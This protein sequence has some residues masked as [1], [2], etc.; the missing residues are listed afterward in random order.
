MATK[1]VATAFGGPEVLSVV[2]ADVP[3]PGAGEV[4]VKVRAAAINPIDFKRFSGAV[5][6]DPST[7]PQPVGSELAGVV[8]AVGDDAEGP[9]GPVSPGDEVVVYPVTGAFA[10]AVT[11]P[12]STVVP[13]PAE[14]PW[15]EASGALLAGA[16]AVH[17]LAVVGVAKSDTVL[18][19]GG[20][21]SVG[22]IAVQ[23]AVETGAT[24]IATASE[25]QH[26]VL[27]GYGAIPVAYGPGL[28]DRVRAAAPGGVD[29]AVDTV[30]TDEAV[31]V[32][33]ELVEDRR[34]IATI[35]AF[36][37]ADTGIRLLGGAPGADPGTEIRRDAWRRLLPAAAS[38]DLTIPVSATFPLTEAADAVRLVQG[39][40][41]GGKVVLLPDS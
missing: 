38:G 39:G 23:L 24:V 33:L 14:V 22:Q 6:S 7:L 1:V 12:A 27:R 40:H 30:G 18:I 2:P 4:T 34:R 41:P 8:T 16:T 35:A 5:G 26:D 28:V 10:D 37:R 15:A 21:G 29:A 9:A 19:H 11:V 25:R 32:S 17:A 13:K 36:G 31:D 3:A 20:S